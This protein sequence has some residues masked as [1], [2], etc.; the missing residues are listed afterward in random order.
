ML[1]QEGWRPAAPGARD[2]R[3]PMQRLAAHGRGGVSP[4]TARGTR[5]LRGGA[6]SRPDD[7]Q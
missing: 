5:A 3:P 7:E 6:G 2:A 1:D 4:P